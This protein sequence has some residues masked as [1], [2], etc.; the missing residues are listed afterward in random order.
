MFTNE[1]IFTIWEFPFLKYTIYTK[2]E[3]QENENML[4]AMIF[5]FYQLSI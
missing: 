3:K 4:G 5:T 1:L 2:R